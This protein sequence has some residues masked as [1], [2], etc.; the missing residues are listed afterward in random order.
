MRKILLSSLAVFSFLANAQT[1][2]YN[3]GFD[4]DFPSTWVKT[5]QSTSPSTTSLWSKAVYTSANTSTSGIFGSGVGNVPVGQAGGENSFALVNYTS[6][7]STGTTAT[8]SN[9]LLSPVINV[10]DGDVVSFYTRKGTDGTVD[11]PDR[12]EVRYSSAATPV[13]PSG[14]TGVGSFTS[15]GVSVNPNLQSGFVYPKV[16]TKYTFTIAGVGSAEV[17]VKF[18]FRYFVTSG[19]TNGNNS[20]IIGIDSFSID[21]ESLAVSDVN[22]GALTIYPNPSKDVLNI[23]GNANYKSIQVYNLLGQKVIDRPFEKSINIS[24]LEKGSYIINL[25]K[26]DNTAENV[27]FIKE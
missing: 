2:V 10:K 14:P 19:G 13:N 21:R 8:I 7:T 25:T 15:L 1:N 11:Y 5:N 9:W 20:D 6:T 16:W 24:S 26:S 23:A 3:Y 27:K 12:L 17:P 22:K 4:T 18:G